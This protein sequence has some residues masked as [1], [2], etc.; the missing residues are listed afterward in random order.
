[1]IERGASLEQKNSKGLAA[2]DWAAG[3]EHWAVL[4][5][6][7]EHA[8]TEE[9][10]KL[11]KIMREQYSMRGHVVIRES[12]SGDGT[13]HFYGARSPPRPIH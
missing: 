11:Q 4:D 7:E 13:R 5:I 1:L 9:L 2:M 8:D 3:R 10:A 12:R 6:L